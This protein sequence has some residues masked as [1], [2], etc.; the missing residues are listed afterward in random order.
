MA[1]NNQSV[2]QA[3]EPLKKLIERIDVKERFERMLGEDGATSFLLSVLNCVQTSTAL[4]NCEPNSVLMAA[5]VSATLNLPVDPSLGMAYI[6]PYGTKAQFQIGYRGLVELGHRSQQY[7]G[8]NADKVVEGEFKGVNRMTGEME[9]DWI[10]DNDE[11]DEKKTIGYVAFFKLKNGFEKSFYMTNKQAL[12]HG[13]KYSKSFK[14]SDGNWSKNFPAMAKKTVLKLLLDKWS[15]KSVQ[16][17]KAIKADQAVVNDW[18]GNNLNYIDNPNNREPI[19]LDALNLERA[20]NSAMNHIKISTT[21]EQLETVYEHIPN[22]VVRKLYDLKL[23]ELT[24]K[25]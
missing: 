13:E 23:E 21:V 10:Q 2:N 19:D 16:M 7:L 15:P 20:I 3:D 24:T 4:K 9:W 12:A 18:D 5:A 17:Q 8:L 22:E 25:Q 14:R 6:I 11:R 1:T